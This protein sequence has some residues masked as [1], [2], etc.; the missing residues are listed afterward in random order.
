LKH[1]RA[2]RSITRAG[3]LD[4]R[5]SRSRYPDQH[6]VIVVLS[7]EDDSPVREIADAAAKR[8]FGD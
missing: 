3:I 4:L 1:R 7:N 2:A 6:V 8:L 5:L